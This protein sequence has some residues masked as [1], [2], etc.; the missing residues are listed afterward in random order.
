MESLC[1]RYGN[2]VHNLQVGVNEYVQVSKIEG[3]LGRQH[4]MI[5]PYSLYKE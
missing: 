4:G 5:N 3:E 1:N 2:I